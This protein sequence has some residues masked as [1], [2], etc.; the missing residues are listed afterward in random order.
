MKEMK[1]SGKMRHK[2]NR[3]SQILDL[4]TV[5]G[6]IEVAELANRLSVSQVTIRKDLDELESRGIIRREHGFAVLHNEDDLNA[7]LAYHY[8]EKELIAQLG[9]SLVQDGETI[10]IGN[11]SCCAL[12]AE[13]LS[14]THKDLTILTNSAFIASYIRGRNNIL[15]TLLGGHY[16]PDAQVMIGPMVRQCAQNFWVNR[17]FI[18]V[19]GWSERT[20][21]TNR[22]QLRAQ[23]IRD[24][25]EQA[26]QVIVLTGSEKFGKRG[27]VPLN[28][29]D[30]IKT[31]ITD[32]K[33]NKDI[34]SLLQERGVRVLRP[35][36]MQV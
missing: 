34:L 15:V 17:F 36:S 7:R 28:L 30:R 19:D 8:Q 31:V 23:A 29:K 2:T 33:I 9:A 25:A 26:E 11:G 5:E 16:Q 20:G 10:M 32:D 21:F 1:G 12:L 35:E 18:G 27:T 3:T 13:T 24:M 6:K 22:D 14:H 4:I